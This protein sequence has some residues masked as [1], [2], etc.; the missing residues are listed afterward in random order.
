MG[1]SGAQLNRLGPPPDF[2]KGLQLPKTPHLGVSTSL[3]ILGPTNQRFQI[4]GRVP[5]VLENFNIASTDYC[6]LIKCWANRAII[7]AHTRHFNT[8]EKDKFHLLVQLFSLLFSSAGEVNVF[9]V[10]K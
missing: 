1:I 3:V 4:P 5:E 8:N 10:F 7:K 6:Q 2:V 9:W